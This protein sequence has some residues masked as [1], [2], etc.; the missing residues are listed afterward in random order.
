MIGSKTLGLPGMSGGGLAKKMRDADWE[1]ARERAWDEVRAMH[2]DLANALQLVFEL[3]KALQAAKKVLQVKRAR[4]KF[5]NDKPL[6][7]KEADLLEEHHRGQIPEWIMGLVPVLQEHQR[8]RLGIERP[9]LLTPGPKQL[10]P[11]RSRRTRAGKRKKP[12]AP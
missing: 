11:P 4:L 6:T 3:E 9:Q 2:A 8:Y 7:L 10:P 12:G 5:R 1:A